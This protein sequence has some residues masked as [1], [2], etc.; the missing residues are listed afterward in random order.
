ML[1]FIGRF[2]SSKGMV[3]M[4]NL[5]GLTR[6][7]ALEALQNAGLKFSGSSTVTT[8]TQSLSDKIQSQSIAASTLLEYESEVSFIYYSYVPYVPTVTYGPCYT[9][10]SPTS[11][12]CSGYTRIVTTTNNRS[13][14]V[15]YDNVFQFEEECSSTS[16]TSSTENSTSCGY[17]PPAATCT[18]GCGTYSAW[19]SC[20]ILY[21]TG[22]Q[23]TRTRTCT[24]TNCA[25]YTEVDTAVCC[26]A[27]CGAWSAW[28]ASTGGVYE[29]TRTCQKTDCTTYTETGIK[30]TPRTTTSCGACSKKSP[31]RKSC[32]TTTIASDCSTSSSSA[33]QAC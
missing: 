11:A 23:K 21:G 8:S 27:T 2:G 20:T 6:P 31:F 28:S 26:V 15:F 19:S 18:S 30:C 9:Y 33:S 17:E 32:T 5:S 13:R 7:Q 3:R 25:T 10:S 4:P 22:G 14:S 29:R 12:T 24:R 16:S 1:G